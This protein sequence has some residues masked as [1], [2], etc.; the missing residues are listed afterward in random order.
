MA[1]V[2]R[3]HITTLPIEKNKNEGGKN[4]RRR[5][6]EGMSTEKG[7]K[8]SE[9]KRHRKLKHKRIQ[10]RKFLKKRTKRRGKDEKKKEENRKRKRQQKMS[11]LDEEKAT[12]VPW[13]VEDE[14]EMDDTSLLR[15]TL[16]T[17]T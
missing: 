5:Q 16:N 13:K 9:K 1:M 2:P 4:G 3:S 7:V 14:R 8:K 10:K 12:I 6:K 15:L 17:T 11:L